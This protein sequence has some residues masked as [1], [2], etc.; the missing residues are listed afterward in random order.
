MDPFFLP[1][2]FFFASL[3]PI[4]MLLCS[5]ICG[6]PCTGGGGDV[7]VCMHAGAPAHWCTG[8][9]CAHV[10][11]RAHMQRSEVSLWH[12]SSGDVHL[13]FGDSI[14]NCNLEFTDE[15]SWEKLGRKAVGWQPSST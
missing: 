10:C 3:N 12:C 4:N 14:S 13:G 5:F 6:C 2:F 15:A 7:H 8:V 9:G 11:V 1:P